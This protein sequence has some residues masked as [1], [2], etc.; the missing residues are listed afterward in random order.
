MKGCFELLRDALKPSISDNLLL[1]FDEA[2]AE[3][4]ANLLCHRY[5]V[6]SPE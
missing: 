1:L 4:L 3:E 2:P 6:E 5:W